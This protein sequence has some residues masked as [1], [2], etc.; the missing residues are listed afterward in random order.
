MDSHQ[1]KA[2]Q[3][4]FITLLISLFISFSLGFKF[5]IEKHLHPMKFFRKRFANF[6]ILNISPY[7][8]KRC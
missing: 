3:S 7:F 2:G 8:L 1:N 6:K 4:L 5:N